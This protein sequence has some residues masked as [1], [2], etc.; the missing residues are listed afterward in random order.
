MFK[1][2][3]IKSV[4]YATKGSAGFDLHSN[5]DVT[6]CLGERAL[7]GTGLF[8]EEPIR[9]DL[10]LFIY[11][12][13]GLA[14]KHGVFVLNSPGLIDSDYLGEIKVLLCN[15]G[16]GEFEVKK[17]DRI[18]QIVMQNILRHNLI[19]IGSVV[20]GTGGMGSTGK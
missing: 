6:I 11:S 10:A 18:A 7:I 5:E 15:F 16:E 9:S 3:K 4:S 1:G 8:L 19:P 13:S 20:R 17:G 14:Y 2:G 12:R